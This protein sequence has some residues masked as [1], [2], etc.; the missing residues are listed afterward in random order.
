MGALFFHNNRCSSHEGGRMYEQFTDQALNVMSYA[1]QEARQLGHE[2]IGTEDILLGLLRENGDACTVLARF[3]LS[4][5]DTRTEILRIVQGGPS[6]DAAERARQLT[7]RAAKVIVYAREE[8]AKLKDACVDTKHLLLGLLREQE[9]VAAQVLM[10]RSL[11]L[12]DVHEALLPPRPEPTAEPAKP[13]DDGTMTFSVVLSPEAVEGLR[14]F[15]D[16]WESGPEEVLAMAIHKS[17]W[18][19][20]GDRITVQR[21][22]Q[23]NGDDRYSATTPPRSSRGVFLWESE[24]HYGKNR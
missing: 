23:D 9:G 22:P 11:R 2:Y 20:E 13:K 18:L 5:E 14:V 7:P 17:L 21:L 6:V 4:V 12:A 1:N 8:A 24:N 16:L 3:G 15:Q 10:N 19:D